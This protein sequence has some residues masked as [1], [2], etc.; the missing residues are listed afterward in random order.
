MSLEGKRDILV[1]AVVISLVLHVGTMFYAR[2]RVMTRLVAQTMKTVRREAMRVVKAMPPPE[3]VRMEEVKDVDAPKDAPAA[4][5]VTAKPVASVPAEEAR[6]IVKSVVPRTLMDVAGVPHPEPEVVTLETRLLKAE[7]ASLQLERPT[8][9]IAAPKVSPVTAAPDPMP[10]APIHLLDT[11][12]TDVSSLGVGFDPERE[13]QDLLVAGEGGRGKF[14]PADEVSEKV[15]VQLV[16]REKA[17]VKDLLN[18]ADAKELGKF[19]NVVMTRHSDG[20]W[21]YF[22]VMLS[23]RHELPVV[24]KDVVLLIDASGSIGKDRM[25]S[26]REAAK[27]ILRTCTN[28]GDRFNLVA[29]RDKFTYAFRRW[30]D[31]SQTAFDLADA[32]LGNVA[33]HGRTDVF[34]TIRSVLT[35]PRDP[36]RPLIALVVTDGEANTGVS[37]TAEILSKF[38]ALN[39]G[40]ISVYMYGVKGSANRELIDV[41]TRGNRGE[42]LIY[43]GWR[44]WLA[45]SGIESLSGRFR[46]PVL[47]DLRVVF[48]SATRAEAYP[49]MLRNIYRGGTLE[50]FGRAPAGTKDIAFSIKGLNGAI[51]YEGYFR[52][53]LETVAEDPALAEAWLAERNI[54]LKLR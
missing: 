32:W 10:A 26:I 33:A 51:P 7:N 47:S 34:D 37:G 28:T 23:P 35:L 27:G 45:G 12:L 11:R 1:A 22:K 54:D 3:P 48:A 5:E 46:D 39:D 24:P 44:K 19:V 49:R 9:K 29:F 25:R 30:Q 16:E 52:F 18:L 4:S 14:K 6:S 41:L 40:L 2:P 36:K 38:T 17:A 20:K 50:V 15:N 31:C 13:R 21:V 53:P 8:P 42:S 43:D